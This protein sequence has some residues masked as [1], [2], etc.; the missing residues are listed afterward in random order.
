MKICSYLVSLQNML[1][2]C[3]VLMGARAEERTI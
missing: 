3:P 2:I 1:T